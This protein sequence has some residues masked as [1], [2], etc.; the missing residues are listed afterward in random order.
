[1]DAFVVFWPL[2]IPCLR[3]QV[4]T[5]PINR[6]VGLRSVQSVSAPRFRYQVGTCPA[7]LSRIRQAPSTLCRRSHV[8]ARFGFNPNF[9]F[10]PW[11][12]FSTTVTYD[13]SYSGSYKCSP[14]LSF[15][16]EFCEQVYRSSKLNVAQFP[17]FSQRPLTCLLRTLVLGRSTRP[18]LLRRPTLRN[19]LPTLVVQSDRAS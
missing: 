18:R 1:M 13:T 8:P 19:Q 5:F 6:L 11:L 17:N 14:Q 2:S 4:G 12:L 3:Y 10:A 15:I 7:E 9:F 16:G